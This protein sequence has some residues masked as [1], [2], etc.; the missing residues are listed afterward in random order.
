MHAVSV[1]ND[2][3]TTGEVKRKEADN[4]YYSKFGYT[5]YKCNYN[6]TECRR[7]FFVV[8]AFCHL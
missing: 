3:H 8:V 2:I 5:Y 4:E 6:N 1:S 7:D